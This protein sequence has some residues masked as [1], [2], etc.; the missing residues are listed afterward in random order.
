VAD[1]RQTEA[2]RAGDLGL[3]RPTRGAAASDSTGRSR[4]IAFIGDVGKL[5]LAPVT[6]PKAQARKRRTPHLNGTVRERYW[7]RQTTGG[8]YSP[9]ANLIGERQGYL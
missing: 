6:M 7:S 5:A 4:P 2:R 3:I 1:P 9:D 8:E